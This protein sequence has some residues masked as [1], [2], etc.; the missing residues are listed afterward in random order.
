ML[1][2]LSPAP[3]VKGRPLRYSVGPGACPISITGDTLGCERIGLGPTTISATQGSTG[4]FRSISS[5]F[6]QERISRS[7][8]A[9]FIR[10][11]GLELLLQNIAPNGHLREQ[12]FPQYIPMITAAINSAC[13]LGN[14][15]G[16]AHLRALK[17]SRPMTTEEYRVF[18]TFSRSLAS[19][20]TS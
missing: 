15:R 6:A 9:I 18:A 4:H 16:I 2:I 7:R 10:V 3:P 14:V 8:S 20:V 12:N 5:H 13:V 1:L 11:L 17:D 19:A